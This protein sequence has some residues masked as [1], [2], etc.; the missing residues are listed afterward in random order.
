MN[1]SMWHASGTNAVHIKEL[2][3]FFSL[4]LGT[5]FLVVVGIALLSLRRRHRGIRQ[6]PLEGSHQPS[7]RTEAKLRTA[8]GIA[9]GFT[10]LIL[11]GLTIVRQDRIGVG[12]A[13]RKYDHRSD[14]DAMVVEGPL[15]EQ[16][17]KP[18]PPHCE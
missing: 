3:V 15:H 9:T 1:Q 4:L 7:A 12:C 6:E 2:A 10:V 16:R 5:V 13:G 17:S 11:F 8:V 18:H 14:R